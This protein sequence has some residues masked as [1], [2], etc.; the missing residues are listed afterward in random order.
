MSEEMDGSL[1]VPAAGDGSAKEDGTRGPSERG[2]WAASSGPT[3][4]ARNGEPDG[5]NNHQPRNAN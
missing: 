4:A 5:A 3:V 2:Q 1:P